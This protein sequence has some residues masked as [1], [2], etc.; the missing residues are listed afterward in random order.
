[1]PCGERSGKINAG[2]FGQLLLR[3][4]VVT[5]GNLLV[6]ILLQER[7]QQLVYPA[8]EAPALRAGWDYLKKSFSTGNRMP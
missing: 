4:T 5:H 1:M 2:A 6:S 3:I 7:L 8:T